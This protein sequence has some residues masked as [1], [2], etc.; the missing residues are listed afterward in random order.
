LQNILLDVQREAADLKLE[1]CAFLTEMLEIN[2]NEVK[3]INER[4]LLKDHVLKAVENFI[5]SEDNLTKIELEWRD[6]MQL[7]P[8]LILTNLVSCHSLSHKLKHFRARVYYLFGRNLR[9][10]S[11]LKNQL[12][13]PDSLNDKNKPAFLNELD[14][15]ITKWSPNILDIYKSIQQQQQADHELLKTK[16]NKLTRSAATIVA[17]SADLS[18]ANISDSSMSKQD[19]LNFINNVEKEYFTE[20][21]NLVSLAKQ[22]DLKVK[23]FNTFCLKP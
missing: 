10:I 16:N 2:L 3:E 4:N 6:F 11:E 1:F 12:R 7:L 8:D 18:Q 9:L 5:E 20:E 19:E 21:V 17:Q 13:K 14:Y 15:S 23:I 22:E